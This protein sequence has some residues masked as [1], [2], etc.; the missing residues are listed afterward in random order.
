MKA[1]CPRC[2][3]VLRAWEWRQD[4]PQCGVN[5]IGYDLQNRLQR[6]ADQAE[7]EFAMVQPCIDRAKASYI[8]S[9]AAIG[10]IVCHL[11]PFGMLL[12]PLYG[13]ERFSM[14]IV[15]VV[16]MILTLAEKELLLPELQGMPKQQLVLIGG[17]A[18][19]TV[20]SILMVLLHLGFTA[21][22]CSEKGRRRL[23]TLDAIMLLIA[24][25]TVVC[26]HLFCKAVSDPGMTYS[27]GIGAFA[28]L[29]SYATLTIYD[30]VLARIGIPVQY[31]Q[32]YI[33]GIPAEEFLQ[34]QEAAA[35]S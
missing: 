34:Q 20:L 33:A 31:T 1:T 18:A 12:L 14:Q 10:R 9:K 24:C 26:L 15:S 8:G 32:T 2:G 21:G 22:S 25:A 3:R 4:C 35:F 19:G 17:L 29:G 11:L 5:M 16:R 28:A 27:V 7:T 13:T 30:I 6:D 23:F